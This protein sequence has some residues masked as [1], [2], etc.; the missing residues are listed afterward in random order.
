[1]DPQ[2]N[3]PRKTIINMVRAFGV[4]DGVSVGPRQ[5]RGSMVTNTLAQATMNGG[6]VD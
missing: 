1:M 4:K 6:T 2:I 3:L 5:L